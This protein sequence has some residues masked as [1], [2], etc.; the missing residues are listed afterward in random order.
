[1]KKQLLYLMFTMAIMCIACS[2]D[3]EIYQTETVENPVTGFSIENDLLTEEGVIT[4]EG[5]GTTTT[6]HVSVIPDN[7]GD[8]E[9]Y[10]FRFG[11]SD[12]NI[13][14]VDREG[15][16]T[17]VASGEAELTVTLV[18]NV[19]VVQFQSKYRVVV[20][21]VVKVEEI[22]VA[23]GFERLSLKIGD[24]YDLNANLTV[25][26]DNAADKSVSYTL[27]EGN[28]VVSLQDG[29][30]E[31]TGVGVAVIEIMANDGSGISKELTV[32][33][34][35]ASDIDVYF[36]FTTARALSMDGNLVLNFMDKA[37]NA[38]VVL[39]K[40]QTAL[41]P[42][43]YSK[44]QIDEISYADLRASD[45]GKNR[46]FDIDN[47]GSFTVQYDETT[48]IYTIKGVF[49]LSAIFPYPAISMG[50]EYTGHIQ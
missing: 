18:N 20:N 12:I 22:I 7:A 31:V 39:I 50:F 21:H 19:N 25:L 35:D 38:A 43:K 14:T 29:I 42:G 8:W 46:N 9:K 48:Q 3:N 49:N 10:S 16:I 34:N 36:E 41:L 26:P 2:D 23:G 24:I 27:K 15:I 6:L 32:E 47:P 11:S 5:L 33:A 1:M 40:Q 37:G 28:G 30:I 17:S 45:L 44:A 4:L 13:F